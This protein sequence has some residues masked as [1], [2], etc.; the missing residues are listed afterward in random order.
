MKTLFNVDDKFL[1]A[2][3]END[4][5]QLDNFEIKQFNDFILN[6]YGGKFD[7][8]KTPIHIGKCDISDSI[9]YVSTIIYRG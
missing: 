2:I 9:S 4:L 1:P 5:K 8:L 3:F 7:D 6:L